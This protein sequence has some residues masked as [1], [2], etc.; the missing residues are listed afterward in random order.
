MNNHKKSASI[1]F[2][3]LMSSTTLA[4]AGPGDPSIEEVVADLGGSA[5]GGFSFVQRCN[6]T[7]GFFL[8]AL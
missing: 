2:A 5:G 4:Y 6:L 1:A 3:M 8:R 7:T